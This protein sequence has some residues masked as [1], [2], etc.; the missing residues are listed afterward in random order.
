MS[1]T[2]SKKNGKARDSEADRSSSRFHK[3][4]KNSPN[5]PKL[6]SKDLSIICLSLLCFWAACARSRRTFV[7]PIHSVH[8]SSPFWHFSLLLERLISLLFK[9]LSPSKFFSNLSNSLLHFIHKTDEAV[10]SLL[11]GNPTSDDNFAAFFALWN[12]HRRI[13]WTFH[14]QILYNKF[15]LHTLQKLF[16]LC[17]LFTD[18]NQL[19]FHRSYRDTAHEIR[20]SSIWQFCAPFYASLPHVQTCQIAKTN[21]SHQKTGL[22]SCGILFQNRMEVRFVTAVTRGVFPARH[23]RS[24]GAN[25]RR[26]R[27]GKKPLAPRLSLCDLATVF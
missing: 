15:T 4:R 22:A 11:T 7:A 12:G 25:F 24:F 19:S 16:A 20:H 1:C 2:N 6:P 9:N 17:T 13:S 5:S 21:R 14:I 10:L 26:K 3:S 27:R 23:D 18:V 8:V